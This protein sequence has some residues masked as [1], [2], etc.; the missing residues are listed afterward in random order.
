M[1]TKA[2]LRERAQ[3]KGARSARKKSETKVPFSYG[4]RIIICNSMAS[5]RKARPDMRGEVRLECV[6]RWSGS[7]QRSLDRGCPRNMTA[8]SAPR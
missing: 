3:L 5:A 8:T 7:R 2:M 6:A 4:A 1:S